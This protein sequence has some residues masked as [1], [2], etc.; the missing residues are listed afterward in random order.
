MNNHKNEGFALA[1]LAASFALT[2][3]VVFYRDNLLPDKF[4][5]DANQIQM[6]AQG[7]I[8]PQGDASYAFAADI[9]RLL[10]V[11]NAPITAGML[12]ILV[13]FLT[14]FIIVRRYKHV[15]INVTGTGYILFFAVLTGVFLG[16]YSKDAFVSVIVLM[17]IT[18]KNG[19]KS[20]L[21]IIIAILSYG[22]YVRS[23]WILIALA[24]LIFRI[25][26]K[27]Q[28]VIKYIFGVVGL[29]IIFSF[30]MYLYLGIA[31]DS[32]RHNV[33]YLRIGSDDASSAIKSFVEIVQPIGGI[34]N[35]VLTVAALII[36]F[37]IIGISA[38][39]IILFF[40]IS[41]LWLTFI[42]S[43]NKWIGKKHHATM[44][45]PATKIEARCIDFL[46]S[47]LAVQALFEPDY[48]SALRHL[49]PLL[50]IMLIVFLSSKEASPTLALHVRKQQLT[51]EI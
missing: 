13:P 27:N 51:N 11:A 43:L 29:V 6:I 38:Y 20:E 7:K 41:T 40:S 15:K 45:L 34:V 49:C 18:L 5:N 10:G 50:P 1:V 42:Y 33:N 4:S 19:W 12:G 44:A 25:L 16:T 2:T 14:L 28:S 36:P 31:P 24:Y 17:V 47:F 48:G 3:I 26:V 22:N 23:Y 21:L 32:Y 8:D 39:H 9:Y 37:P 30:S 46:L 35:N